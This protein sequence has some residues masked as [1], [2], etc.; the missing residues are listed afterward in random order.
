[1]TKLIGVFS[2]YEN[3]SNNDRPRPKCFSNSFHHQMQWF[4]HILV[5]QKEP[6]TITGHHQEVPT[7]VCVRVIHMYLPMATFILICR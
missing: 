3:A 6:F 4:L 7:C 5:P 1:M 2:D